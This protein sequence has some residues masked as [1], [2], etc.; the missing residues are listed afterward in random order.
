MVVDHIKQHPHVPLVGLLDKI[1]QVI[2]AAE[3]RI[4]LQEVLNSVSVVGV[5][6][7]ALPKDR[8][9]PDGANA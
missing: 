7:P 8:A 9:Q 3:S 4:D 1:D 6:M 2:A 5:E